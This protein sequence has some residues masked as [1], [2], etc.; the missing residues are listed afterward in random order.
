MFELHDKVFYGV[1][2]VCEI[3]EIG[4]PPIKGIEGEYYFLQPMFDD[5]GIIYSPLKSTKQM[6]R[7]IITEA[8]GHKLVKLAENCVKDERLNE[9]LTTAEYDDIIKSQN[10]FDI[11]HLIRYLYNVKNERAKDLRK[12]K[13]A[14]SRILLTARKLLYGEMAVVLNRTYEDVCTMMDTYLQR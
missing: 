12:M 8:E 13:S 3:V 14:D 1:I 2:G 11:L 4:N 7:K 10:S 6:M 5:K 9:K